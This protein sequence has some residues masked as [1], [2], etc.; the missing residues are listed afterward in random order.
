MPNLHTQRKD[1]MEV[2]VYLA[3]WLIIGFLHGV[4]LFFKEI[5]LETETVFDQLFMV[6]FATVCGPIGIAVTLFQLITEPR[7]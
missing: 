3:I 1:I 2:L 5:K 7:V 4:Y 6:G